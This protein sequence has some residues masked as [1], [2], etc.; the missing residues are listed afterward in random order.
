MTGEHKYEELRLACQED[1]DASKTKDERNALG[2]FATPTSLAR[3]IVASV[4]DL[5]PGNESIRFFDPGIGTGSFYS[6]LRDVVSTGCIARAEGFE[7]DPHYGI[8]AQELWSKT[9]LRIHLEDFTHATAPEGDA[10]KFNL[11]ICNPPYVRHHHIDNRDKKR[12]QAASSKASGVRIGGLAGLYCHFLALADAWMAEEGVA[13]WL[14]PSEFM[15][16]NYGVAMKRYLLSN[17]ELMRVHRFDPN[18]VQ[19]DDALV[20]SAV[21]VF[22]KRA[23]K[24]L[25][26]VTFTFGGTLE[27]P[28]MRRMVPTEALRE[29]HKWTRFPVA[30]IRQKHTGTK[31]GDLFTVRRGLATGDNNFFILRKEEIEE[32]KLPW[33]FFRPILPSARHLPDDIVEA[34][35]EGKPDLEKRLFLLDCR[36]PEDVVKERYPRL[37]SYLEEGVPAVAERYLCRHRKPWYSQEK[38][39]PAPFICTY[40]GRSDKKSGRAFRFI[41]NESAATAANVYLLLYPNPTLAR[42]LALD[43]PLAR[44]VWRFLN[45]IP[46]EKLLGE[47]RVYGGGLHK[48]EPKELANVP[49]DEIGKLSALPVLEG[50]ND[51]TVPDHKARRYNNTIRT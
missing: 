11:L 36:L 10:Q 33:E 3:D 21:V 47:G 2:Q 19:F 20:S 13:G 15:D 32:R 40:L 17:V 25:H 26:E 46:E 22:R 23:P 31:L 45:D 8:P 7:V 44:K 9:P 49:A 24:R 50:A 51:H 5:L 39:P 35:K 48:L 37:W 28:R 16:V 38:R 12:L 41:L 34:D 4:S 1:L 30:G 14:I 42:T 29:E 18:D 6:A 43:P 27:N